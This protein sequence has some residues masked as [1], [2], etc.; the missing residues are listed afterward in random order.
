MLPHPLAPAQ[1]AKS[2]ILMSY[3]RKC[4]KTTFAGIITALRAGNLTN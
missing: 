4:I 3:K 2:E 1:K